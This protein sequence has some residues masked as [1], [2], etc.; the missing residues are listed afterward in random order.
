MR[1]RNSGLAGLYLALWVFGCADRKPLAGGEVSVAPDAS[2]RVVD[3]GADRTAT[4]DVSTAPRFVM[5][6]DMEDRRMDGLPTAPTLSAFFWQ[7]PGTV[8]VGNWFVSSSD[9]STNDVGRPLI[10]PPR[11]DSHGA[12]EIHGGDTAKAANLWAQLDHPQGRA[13]DLSAYA[14]LVFWARLTGSGGILDVALDRL[15]GGGGVYF[16]SDF[17]SLPTWELFVPERWQQFTLSFDDLATPATGVVSI[18][19]VVSGTAGPF[20]LWIDDVALLCRD[21]CP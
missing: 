2:T 20:D 15:S 12:R 13:I 6:D 21:T 7:S 1:L 10:D 16:K 5:I 4:A 14:G 3:G 17:T 19:F 11:G 8:R 18:D 9:G